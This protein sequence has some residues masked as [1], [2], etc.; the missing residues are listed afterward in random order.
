[1]A[2]RQAEAA[3]HSLEPEEEVTVN[4]SPKKPAKLTDE[5]IRGFYK[6]KSSDQMLVREHME[7]NEKLGI[8]DER[9][10]L[11]DEH[12]KKKTCMPEM[13]PSPQLTVPLL[14]YQREALAWMT[15][16]EK[17][18]Y[19]G[20]ILADEMGMGKTIQAISLILENTRI[21]DVKPKPKSSASTVIRGGTL[22]ICPLVAVMQ[23][24]S[25]IERFVDKGHLSIYIHHGNKRE[26]LASRIALYDIVLT[27][28]SIIESEIRKTL[29]WAKVPCKYCKKKYLPDKLILHNKYFCGP[30][31]KKTRLQDKQQTK[32]GSA[33]KV[34]SESDSEID[35]D[36][37]KKPARKAPA[38][39]GKKKKKASSDEGSDDDDFE[40]NRKA[41]KGKS[42]LHLIT[43]TRI[44]LDEAHYIK[45]RRCNTARGVFELKSEFKWCLT[46]KDLLLVISSQDY[47][48]ARDACT[49]TPLQNRIGELFSLVRF[50]QIESYAF[51]HCNKCDCQ[52]LDYEYVFRWLC[53]AWLLITD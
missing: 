2:Q 52:L 19:K 14:P 17:S 7:N 42:P 15:A 45:D 44:V 40:P 33:K 53:F 4:S 9:L 31:A 1:M 29:G 39:K 11:A 48:E 51:Y 13:E 46:G 47:T 38:A 12:Y 50:L 41:T 8:F 30:N 27:T 10:E 34:A 20:G 6:L 37:P 5:P 18:A 49:G 43:W 35:D 22:V 25:E 36:Y 16:Q 24:K 3:K 32:R 28:Y 21:V 26:D 23:W